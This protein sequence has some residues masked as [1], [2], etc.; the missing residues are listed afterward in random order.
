VVQFETI[1]LSETQGERGVPLLYG[2]FSLPALM[3][4]VS[5]K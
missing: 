1:C 2:R 3:R 4:V 5:R